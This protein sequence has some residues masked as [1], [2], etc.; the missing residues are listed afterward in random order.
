MYVIFMQII[1]F[2]TVEH[3]MPARIGKVNNLQKFDAKFFNMSAIEP[4]VMDP[5]A[6]TLLEHTFEAIMDAGINPA[7]LQGTRTSVI[8]ATIFCDSR[9]ELVEK[10]HV[11]N[12]Q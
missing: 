6:R 5:A 11:C 12:I 8:T 10:C 7:E 3:N 2:L 9:W 1:L 4:N